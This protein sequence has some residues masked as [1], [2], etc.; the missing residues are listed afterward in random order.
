MCEHAQ[1]QNLIYSITITIIYAIM[2]AVRT[3]ANIFFLPRVYSRSLDVQKNFK[4]HPTMKR[5]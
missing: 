3:F 4:L 1:A 2:I 5:S